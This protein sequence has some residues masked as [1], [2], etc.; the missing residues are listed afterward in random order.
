MAVGK[1]YD[2]VGSRNGI[3][4]LPDSNGASYQADVD[5]SNNLH[6]N[7][8]TEPGGVLNATGQ[9]SVGNTAT[10]IIAAGTRQGV[11]ITN[12]SSSVT[13]FLGGRG[14]TTGNG[15]ELLP[16][17]SK[18]YPIVSAVYGIVALGS[19]TVSYVEVV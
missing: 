5:P 8:Q 6:V 7:V 14:V 4:G 10:Q 9:V 13:V 18:T 12:P 1:T 2:G 16:G 15:D 19:Q 17:T 11:M 3:L